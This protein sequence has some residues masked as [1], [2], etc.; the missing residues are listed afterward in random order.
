REFSDLAGKT[1]QPLELSV[2]ISVLQ[3][4]Q[5][6]FADVVLSN[7]EKYDVNPRKL[8]LEITET[9]FMSGFDKVL[10]VLHRLRG[11]GVSLSM[12]DFGTGY[13]SLSLLRSLP[14]DELKIDK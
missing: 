1:S 9:L 2:N 7:I 5:A 12:D 10:P 14:I 4:M 11:E 8:T 3:F 13:S 6:D